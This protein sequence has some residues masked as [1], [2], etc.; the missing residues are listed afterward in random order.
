MVAATGIDEEKME[1]VA[2]LYGQAK[3]AVI[4]YG[5]GLLE[6]KDASVVTTILNL[7]NIT[8]NRRGNKLR[9]I[10]LKPGAN[11]RGAWELGLAKG[12]GEDKPKALY[13]LLGD[14][15]ESQELLRW[16]MGVH[17]L[18]VQ[19]SYYSPAIYMADV[20]LPSPIWA[21]REGKYVAMDGRVQQ[22]KQVLE[23]K[24]G[25]PRDEEVLIEIS[26]KFGCALS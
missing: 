12:I 6:A 8:G 15:P 22:L 24:D 25:L 21:E 16:L 10:S 7:A 19:A 26:K 14:E 5:E 4:I 18:V 17:F 9:V 1:L 3:H 11:S 23:P 20:V 2:E 13:L